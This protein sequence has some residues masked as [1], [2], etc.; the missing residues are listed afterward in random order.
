MEIDNYNNLLLKVLVVTWNLLNWHS[1]RK[2]KKR[3]NFYDRD[4]AI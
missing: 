2:V 3:C 1:N 4:T